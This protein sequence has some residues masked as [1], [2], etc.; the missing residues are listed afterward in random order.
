LIFNIIRIYII[1]T[2]GQATKMKASLVTDSNEYL[3]GL[4]CGVGVFVLF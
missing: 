3:A 4:I 1:L 2:A